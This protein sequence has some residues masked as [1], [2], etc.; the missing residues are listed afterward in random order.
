M[1]LLMLSGAPAGGGTTPPPTGLGLRVTEM[2]A[3]DV[4]AA[5]DLVM[6]ID[7][8]A[9]T[10][11]NKKATLSQ[12][13]ASLPPGPAGPAGPAGPTGPAGPAGATGPAGPAGPA[14]SGGDI[15]H[16]VQASL[17][18]ASLA[19]GFVVYGPPVTFAGTITKMIFQVDRSSGLGTCVLDVWK[20]NTSA[21]YPPTVANTICGGNKPTLG[22]GDQYVE[23]TTLTDWTLAVA[24]GDVFAVKVDGVTVL[25][26]VILTLEVTP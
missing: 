4:V 23:S 15:T 8:V 10:P 12:V 11:T 5:D 19:T 26:G 24:I 2:P 25:P 3:I 21:G 18:G 1:L 22:S 20:K 16:R 6:V 13:A 7:D 14:G 9:G 17:S